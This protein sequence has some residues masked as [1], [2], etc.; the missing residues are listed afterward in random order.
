MITL[1]QENLNHIKKDASLT[2]P[3]RDVF[4]LP[5]RVLQFGTGVLLR[6][7]PDYFIDKANRNGLFN[8][9]I[10]VVKSTSIGGTDAFNIQQGLYSTC[11]R[12]IEF[13]NETDEVIINS[14][15]SKVLNATTQ[16]SEVLQKA[17]QPAIQI[18]ISN[19][20][21][22]GIAYLE[23]Y[24]KE[25][26]PESFPGK[27]LAC[28]YSR[29]LAFNGSLEGGM[30]IIPTELIPENGKRL[31]SILIKL[32]RYNQ[33]SEAFITWLEESNHF[34][35]S[36][37]DRIVPGK[38]SKEEAKEIEDKYGYKDD[39]MIMAESFRLWAIESNN[40][41]V[42]QI[43]SFASSDDGVVITPDIEKF[44]EL[45][46]RLLNGTHTFSCGLAFLGEFGTVKNAMHHSQMMNFIQDITLDEIASSVVSTSISFE[47]AKRFG[48]QVLDRFR[49]PFIAHLWSS[50]TV[51]YTAKI[52][53]RC[54]QLIKR[55]AELHGFVGTNMSM[56]FA[57]WL[58]YMRSNYINGKYIGRFNDIE[59][60]I[61]DDYSS[62]LCKL[63]NENGPE[64]IVREVLANK[65]LWGESL[66]EIVGFEE[67]VSHYLQI[68][69]NEGV[70]EAICRIKKQIT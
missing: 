57:G 62:I 8:G 34:C 51:Q 63:W 49:N 2:I 24:I 5:E 52:K 33:L 9:R 53:T 44:R 58:L 21:E 30:V 66:L 14:S 10:V 56:G 23:E 29:Y 6:G 20:T 70:I 38:L 12:G 15:I 43:L 42:N 61:N 67:Q 22:V 1:S 26:I 69:M 31:L 36:L 17:I 47:D 65:E 46:L 4:Q 11:I 59:Y 27:L 41:K 55:Y 13:G 64:G 37:V 45:K 18:V 32:A 54:I 7:L 50:I 16:W 35:S 19:T 28:L 60:T 48:E 40:E 39:L 68:L 25:G 3:S